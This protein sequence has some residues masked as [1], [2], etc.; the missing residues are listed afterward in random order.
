MEVTLEGMITLFSPEH[1]AK[2]ES[3]MEARP[4]LRT[5]SSKAAH[6]ENGAAPMLFTPA[7]MVMLF[8]S[9]QSLKA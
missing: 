4:S 1:P 3:P 6:P 8:K 7:G 2:K 9:M 5:T